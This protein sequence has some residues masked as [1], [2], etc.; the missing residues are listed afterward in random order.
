MILIIGYS[1]ALTLQ[2]VV[3]SAINHMC[4]IS[5]LQLHAKVVLVCNEPS[6]I[7]LKVKIVKY[8]SELKISVSSKQKTLKVFNLSRGL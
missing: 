1:K 8:F 3:E 7:E 4:T 2:A 6:I 5:C